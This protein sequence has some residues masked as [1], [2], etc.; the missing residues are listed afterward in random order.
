M[1]ALLIPFLSLFSASCLQQ[2]L[3]FAGAGEKVTVSQTPPKNVKKK[4]ILFLKPLKN[5][6][7]PET[8]ETQ[9]ISIELSPGP[10]EQLSLLANEI[11]MPVLSHS[12]CKE[13][14]SDTVQ[15]DVL[16]RMHAFLA[17]LYVMIGSTKVCDCCALYQR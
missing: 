2:V 9:V 15:H 6:V 5:A 8:I 17:N 14:W 4:S 16:D 1:A 3:Y 7:K 12:E 13:N 11:I 10:L